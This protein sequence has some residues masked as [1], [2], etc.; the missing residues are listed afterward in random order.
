M[1]KGLVLITGASGLLGRQVLQVFKENDWDVTGLCFSKP[2]EGLI[3]HDITDSEATIQLIK[4][5]KPNLV[6]HCAAQ[7]FPDQ[8]EKDLEKSW[9]LNVTSNRTLSQVYM[10]TLDQSTNL[11]QGETVVRENPSNIVLRIP[12]LY[13]NVKNLQESALTSLLDTVKSGKP[14]KISSYEVR[15]PAHT[16]DIAKILLDLAN[17]VQTLEVNIVFCNLDNV[18]NSSSAQELSG[19]SPGAPRPRDVEMD[20][21]KLLDLGIK[22]HTSFNKGFM[23]AMQPFL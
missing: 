4:Q 12:V 1:V 5:I 3:Q 14:G 2:I 22:H 16:D 8:M 9:N 15:C 13:G 11:L 17:I 20:R 19:P 7:R 23:E 18:L 10:L 6:V 21:S